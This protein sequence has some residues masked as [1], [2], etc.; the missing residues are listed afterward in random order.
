MMVSHIGPRAGC[1]C[2]LPGEVVACI[3]VLPMPVALLLVFSACLRSISTF[4]DLVQIAIFCIIAKF[5]LIYKFFHGFVSTLSVR[6]TS[7]H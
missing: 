3:V 1:G 2:C 7:C 6:E 4:V 5:V